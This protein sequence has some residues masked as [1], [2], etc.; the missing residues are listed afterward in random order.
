MLAETSEQ[1]ISVPS[2]PR[3]SN[4]PDFGEGKG[5]GWG[6]GVRTHHKPPHFLPQ[7]FSVLFSQCLDGLR[8]LAVGSGLS[9]VSGMTILW[10]RSKMPLATDSSPRT[11][12]YQVVSGFLFHFPSAGMLVPAE[13][14]WVICCFFVD[15]G[16]WY[17][18]R[19]SVLYNKVD[20]RC[21]HLAS[22]AWR[23]GHSGRRKRRAV[24][25][26]AV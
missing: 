12:S 13:G 7:H 20:I 6:G 15:L 8:G 3:L 23:S 21:T 22:V 5:W 24:K 11:L 14:Q 16:K 19:C 18:N 17:C 26:V 2:V 9:K 25:K 1:I 10:P 4:P